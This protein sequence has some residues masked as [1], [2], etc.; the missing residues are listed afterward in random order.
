MKSGFDQ[1]QQPYRR[2]PIY[3]HIAPARSHG[4]SPC[5][6]CGGAVNYTPDQPCLYSGHGAVLCLNCGAAYAPEL[7]AMLLVAGQP[8][9]DAG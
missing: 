7:V 8:G 4:S 9:A 5:I 2:V 3:P 6:E 1:H